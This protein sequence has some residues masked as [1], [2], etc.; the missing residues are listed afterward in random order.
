MGRDA[1]AFRRRDHATRPLVMADPPLRC[2][3]QLV[4]FGP[5]D[6][7]CERGSECEAF[8]YV[9]DFETYRAAHANTVSADV[10]M[11]PEGEL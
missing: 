5:G 3:G 7:L 10:I 1:L 8:E 9:D 11:D 4:V 6:V 2:S